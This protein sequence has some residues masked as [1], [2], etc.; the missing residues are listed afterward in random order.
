MLNGNKSAEQVINLKNR[1]REVE[2]ENVEP[3]KKLNGVP[4]TEFE[5]LQSE[6]LWEPY[7][8]ERQEKLDNVRKGNK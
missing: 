5:F 4:I 7:I 2:E 3:Y 8:L 1:I 6:E